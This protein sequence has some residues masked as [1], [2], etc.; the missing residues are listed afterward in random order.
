MKKEFPILEFDDTVEALIDPFKQK[1]RNIPHLGVLTFF[2]DVIKKLASEGR[3]KQIYTMKSEIGDNPVY[4]F[5]PDED[6]KN[7][8][9]VLLFHPGLGAP[10]SAGTLDELIGLGLEHVIVCGG[11]G[12]LDG[13]IARG[14]IIIPV[15][16]NIFFFL[17]AC[18]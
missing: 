7:I 3:I 15:K 13:D 16:A 11:A 17:V 4:E 1:K 10:L 8:Q 12:V 18:W 9:G 2:N 6:K 14:H 5:I